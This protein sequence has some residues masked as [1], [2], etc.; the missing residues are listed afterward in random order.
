MIQDLKIFF[1]R[2]ARFLSDDVSGIDLG[3]LEKK[4]AYVSIYSFFEF[5]KKGWNVRAQQTPVIDLRKSEEEL[6]SQFHRDA[7]AGVKKSSETGGLDFKIPDKNARDSYA[8]YK[9]VKHQDGAKPDIE[10][11]FTNCVYF[12]AYYNGRI[13]VTMSFY[14][15]GRIFRSKHIASLRKQNKELSKLA[16]HASRRLI[17]EIIKYGKKNGYEKLCLTMPEKKA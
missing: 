13:L 7:K 2:Y 8:F 14:D 15:N 17:W 11:E 12:N 10:R 9:I 4:Y 6:F 5:Q 3:L 1:L 16:G